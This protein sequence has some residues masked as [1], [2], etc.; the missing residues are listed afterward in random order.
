[1]N[2]RIIVLLAVLMFVFFLLLSCEKNPFDSPNPGRLSLNLKLARGPYEDVVTKDDKLEI[3]VQY[4]KGYVDSSQW[5]YI[6][7]KDSLKVINLF[8]INEE[9][10]ILA[11]TVVDTIWIDSITY[12]LDTTSVSEPLI[13]SDSKGVN[14]PPLNYKFIKIKAVLEDTI[15]VLGGKKYKIHKKAGTESIAIVD[16]DLTI[17]EN[18]WISRD[19]FFDLKSSIERSTS[20]PDH[21][22]FQPYFYIE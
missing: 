20:E 5:S 1:M 10:N 4:V 22:F 6:I 13:L 7:D 17:K 12:K 9:G 11:E 16:L 15:M 21:Y 14:L 8:H 18:E 3:V 19:L 2:K